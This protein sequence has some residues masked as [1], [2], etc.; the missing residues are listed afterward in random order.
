MSL[1][2]ATLAALRGW[3][4][5]SAEQAALRDRFVAYLESD[6]NGTSRTSA[7]DHITCGALVLDHTGTRVLLNLHGKAGIWVAFGGHCEPEDASPLAAAT[8]ELAEESG[9]SAFEVDPEIAQLDVHPVDFCTPHGH[10]HHLD[11]RFVARAGADAQ[12][13]ISDESLDLRWF[14][15]DDVPTQE[16][17]MLALIGIARERFAAVAGS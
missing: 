3:T 5:P 7:P 12:E 10:V 11:I 8:R 14:D 17:S 16:A 9:L 6:P 4:A 1:Y 13:Q 2:D 15:V